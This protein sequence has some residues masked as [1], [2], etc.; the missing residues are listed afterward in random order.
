MPT[1]DFRVCQNR[2]LV[3][4]WH[5]A[6]LRALHGLG[7]ASSPFLSISC[8]SN[9]LSSELQVKRSLSQSHADTCCD[10]KWV[11]EGGQSFL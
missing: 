7:A 5:P 10:L 2:L 9:I 6:E 3:P 8:F 4:P 11:V 1:L